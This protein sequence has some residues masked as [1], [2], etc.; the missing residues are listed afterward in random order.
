MTT[1]TSSNPSSPGTRVSCRLR[2]ATGSRLTRMDGRSGSCRASLL[3]PTCRRHSPIR[4]QSEAP[5]VG[6]LV[7]GLLELAAEEDERER[8]SRRR[9]PPCYLSIDA[10]PIANTLLGGENSLDSN[11]R[12]TNGNAHVFS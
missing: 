12:L 10:P 8:L 2:R 9:A 5:P 1:S 7:S 4:G 3:W 6:G 11:K